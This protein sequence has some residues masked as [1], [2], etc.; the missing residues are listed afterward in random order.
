MPSEVN[1]K[2]SASFPRHD[3]S[4]EKKAKKE[5]GAQAAK[6]IWFHNDQ[7]APAIFYNDRDLYDTYIKYAF[8]QQDENKYKP[9]LGI[10][11]QNAAQSFLGGIRWQIKNF[12]T[13]RVN[14]TISRILSKKYDPVATAIDLLSADRKESF[15]SSVQTW[16]DQQQ[17]LAERQQML[18]ISMLPEGMDMDSLPINDDDLEVYMQN[19]Y[20]LNT[21]I[22]I[23][24]G[25]QHHLKRLGFDDI[26]EQANFYQV[27]LPAAGIWTG[28]DSSGLP[29]MRV[30][31]PARILAPRSEFQNYKRLAYAGYVD[32]Y[33]V[34]EFKQMA[35]SEFESYEME[36]IIKEFAKKG[37]YYYGTG[38]SNIGGP[39]TDRDV[40]KIRILHFEIRSDN[41]YVYLERKDKYGN[42]RFVDK[43]FDYYHTANQQDN[44]RSKYNGERRIHRYSY[45]TVY[46]GYWIVG[47]D[48][49]FDYGEKNY[50]NG[51]LGYK[52]RASNMV[53]GRSTCLLKQMIPSLDALET[54]DRKIQ[55]LVSSA[56]P[57]GVYID[58]FALR[59]ASFKMGG[60]DMTPERLIELFFQKGILI[61]DSGGEYAAGKTDKPII[62]IENGI[63]KDLVNY[64]QLMQHE[65]AMLD[66][67]IG[68]NSVSSASTLSPETGARV[69]QQ[70]DMATDTAL[71]HL[72]RA[73]RALC[74]ET[75]KSIAHLHRLSVRAR[76][77][78]YVS[79]LG[80][81]AVKRIMESS[82][83]ASYGIDV[84]ARPTQQEWNI[85]YQ[86]MNDMVKAGYLAPEDRIAL[87]RSN[88]LK[89]AYSLMKSLTRKRK[90]EAAQQQ[91]ALVQENAQVQTMS[92]K[93]TADN[94]MQELGM[95]QEL[96]IALEKERRKTLQLQHQLKL[97]E[98]L[99]QQSVIGDYKIKEKEMDGTQKMEQI[100]LNNRTRPKT[101]A[102]N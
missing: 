15:K 91:S 36:A 49:V 98:I 82:D 42:D 12:A 29:D 50:C 6:A 38:N 39:Q 93:Q 76:P 55:Q 28:M 43:P 67:V 14:S 25:T 10:N 88:S 102:S 72:F 87:R 73:D 68:Y 11:P 1:N 54:Y 56:I 61:G 7:F 89:Q 62:E 30:L 101:T 94:K 63:G 52:L 8:G 22:D 70:M 26:K 59:K 13:K 74:L 80:E 99:A 83:Y 71:D 92:N 90:K 2:I 46:S 20:K 48:K 40:D 32:E 33:T 47:S 79:I 37:D 66:E 9:M 60:Q 86:E 69:A 3:I 65:L 57:K 17:W 77:D 23:E 95:N 78:Y 5:W 84:E 81:P 97:Q 85:F 41:E 96:E 51:E 27:V 53:E 18:G 75:Y 19:D 4:P 34:A 35:G 24:I 44:F 45:P 100:R 31:N 58:L 64:L 16:M 21:E